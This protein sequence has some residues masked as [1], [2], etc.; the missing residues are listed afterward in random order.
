MKGSKRHNRHRTPKVINKGL[1]YEL[2]AKNVF[3]LQKNKDIILSH[4]DMRNCVLNVKNYV[5]MNDCDLNY[6]PLSGYFEWWEKAQKVMHANEDGQMGFVIR[7]ACSPMSGINNCDMAFEDGHIEKWRI[8]AFRHDV[9]LWLAIRKQ[10]DN[11]LKYPP[12]LT[13]RDVIDKLNERQ[14]LSP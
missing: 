5:C 2:L 11:V 1:D 6:M 9:I 14:C 4:E 8:R 10:Y 7:W 13:L 3:L 12:K